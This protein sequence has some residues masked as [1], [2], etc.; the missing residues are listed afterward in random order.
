MITE[1]LFGISFFVYIVYMLYESRTNRFES[2]II[3][4]MLEF[5]RTLKTGESIETAVFKLSKRKDLAAQAFKKILEKVKNGASMAEAFASYPSKSPIYKY[6]VEL[7]R[8]A[9]TS[10]EDISDH[11]QDIAEKLQDYREIEKNM[12]MKTMTPVMVMQFFGVIIAPL[13]VYSLPSMMSLP[14][15]NLTPYFIGVVVASF[16]FFDYIIYY[17][18]KRSLFLLPVFVFGYMMVMRYL[19]PVAIRFLTGG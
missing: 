17:D 8:I 16:A 9:E 13:A 12:N 6:L 5:S 7:V 4:S 19:V 10:D 1:L 11:M 18:L 15:H 14:L 2:Q 3:D